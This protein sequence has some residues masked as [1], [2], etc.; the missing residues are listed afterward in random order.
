LKRGDLVIVSLPG[1]YGKPRPAVVL[2]NDKLE[3]RL[4][5]YVIALL[6]T[7]DDGT[8]VLRVPVQPTLENGLREDSRVM[9][10]K[11]Y[12]I[13]EHRIHQHIGRL[14]DLSLR[15]IDR[16]LFMLLDLDPLKRQ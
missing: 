8:K 11:L 3:G 15:K 4:E 14:D 9:V 16:A 6:T 1:D 13:P 2:Q 5:S 12:A 10:D 7:F